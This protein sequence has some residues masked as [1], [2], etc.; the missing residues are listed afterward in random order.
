MINTICMSDENSS[1]SLV[2]KLPLGAIIAVFLL[3]FSVWLFFY[4]L[5]MPLHAP[6]TTVVAAIMI[7]VVMGARAIWARR[8]KG[9]RK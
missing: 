9:R 4:E 6:A 8:S 2:S 5:D 1:P 7:G 3:T